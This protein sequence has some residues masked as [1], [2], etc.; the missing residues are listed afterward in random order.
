M[1][2]TNVQ[3]AIIEREGQSLLRRRNRPEVERYDG[4][5]NQRPQDFRSK[6]CR[7]AFE[8]RRE[9][10]ECLGFQVKNCAGWTA[11]SLAISLAILRSRKTRGLPWFW[12]RR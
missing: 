5:A 9:V 3:A 10:G 6:S 4:S 11:N 8:K 1:I 7:P 2:V 12:L